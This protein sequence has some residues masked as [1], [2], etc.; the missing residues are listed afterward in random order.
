MLLLSCEDKT[1]ISTRG[2]TSCST[3]RLTKKFPNKDW[4]LEKNKHWIALGKL[5]TKIPLRSNA[6]Q[7]A[8]ITV[9][10]TAD[11]IAAVTIS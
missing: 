2:N 5:R 6:L 4:K 7:D 9:V 1:L 8:A 10:R 11:S 3:Q